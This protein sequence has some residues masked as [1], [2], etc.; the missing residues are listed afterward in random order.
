MT[1]VLKEL[2][3]RRDKLNSKAEKFR[4][5]RDGL[6]HETKKWAEIRDQHNSEVKKRVEKA[7][8]H[9][10]TRDELNQKVREAKVKREELNRR[11]NKLSE[12][13]TRLKK[14]KLPNEGDK[15]SK[16]RSE[17]RRLEHKQMTSV[18]TSEKERELIDAIAKL[19]ATIRKHEQAFEENVEVQTALKDVKV[20][21]DEAETQHRLV[22]TCAEQAQKEHDD[23]VALYAESD[24]IR[25]EADEAQSRFLESKR[26]ADHEH[27]WHIAYIRQVHD[28][29]RIITSLRQKVK[30]EQSARSQTQAKKE[31]TDIFKKFKGGEKLSTEDL[32][33][34]QKAGYI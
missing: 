17:I 2:E 14:E 4:R 10:Q 12:E 29:D 33:S 26:T 32:M 30:A 7:N 13:L 16:L 31:A 6:N 22:S 18:L 1:D 27:R 5:S 34:L 28:F 3:Q 19:Q 8:G 23:M 20:A 25:K 11:Y 24:A 15:L 9:R 21:K